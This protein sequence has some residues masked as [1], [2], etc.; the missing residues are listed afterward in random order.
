MGGRMGLDMG[1]LRE[2]SGCGD[3]DGDGRGAGR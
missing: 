1:K 2:W 3:G